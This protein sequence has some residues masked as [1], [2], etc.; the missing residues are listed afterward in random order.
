MLPPEHTQEAPLKSACRT[1]IS[2]GDRRGWWTNMLMLVPMLMRC[3]RN[4]GYDRRHMAEADL[5][6]RDVMSREKEPSFVMRDPS[7]VKESF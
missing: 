3:L 7:Y 2:G 1:H 4:S 6:M 5:A